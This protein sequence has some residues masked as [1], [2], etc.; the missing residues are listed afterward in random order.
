MNKILFGSIVLLLVAG[1]GQARAEQ[2]SLNDCLQLAKQQNPTLQTE[3]VN[4]PLAAE[5]IRESRSA[6][7]PQVDLS[8]GYT[9]QAD[10]QQVLM[11]GR[12]EPTQDKSYAHLSLSAEQLLYDFGRTKSEV[13]AMQAQAD[14]AGSELS[15]SVQDLLLST[16]QA[17]FQVLAAQQL[18]K[19]A[20]EEVVQ[21]EEHRRVAQALHEQ[22]VVTRND[23]LQ[24]E[25]RLAA[26]RQQQLVREGGL[27]N[28]WLALNYL[29][30][31]TNDSRAELE[32][33]SLPDL[34]PEL[35]AASLELR[36]EL[37]AQ[38]QR[39]A[40]AAARVEVMRSSYRPELFARLAADYVEN[41]YV[42]EQTIYSATL[43]LRVNL[44][45][46]QAT[47][48]KLRQALLILNRE[49][50]RLHDLQARTELEYRQ[51]DNDARVARQRIAVAEQAIRQAEENL[52]INRD[53]YR[54]QVGTATEVLDAQT[55]LT[56]SRT[57][58]ALAEFDYQV[59][60]ARVKRAAGIL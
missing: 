3:A 26:S 29:I 48:S 58:L 5:Q 1:S 15:G 6:Y 59:A 10:P 19:S 45:D 11:S 53:R 27:D 25:V 49:Q 8:G 51:A 44:F 56:Q 14:A 57:D 22:G 40:A 33:L 54:E 23:L 55:L 17:Y 34:P 38:Q 20:R 32:I 12:S 24:A 30:G 31:R 43:G 46:G 9:T 52:R 2:L 21:V 42:K 18:L 36:P 37:T 41:S 47:T 35:A 16:S 28:A 39:V 13:T 4:L 50:R 7:L 60:V